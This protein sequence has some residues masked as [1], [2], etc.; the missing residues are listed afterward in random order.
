M[1]GTEALEGETVGDGG[2]GEVEGGGLLD[3]GGVGFHVLVGG[4]VGGCCCF[5]CGSGLFCSLALGW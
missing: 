2:E 5:R 1:F 4:G 3:E